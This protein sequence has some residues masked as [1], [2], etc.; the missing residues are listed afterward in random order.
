LA[1]STGGANEPRVPDDD[2]VSTPVRP[3]YTLDQ[4]L[5][6]ITDENCHAETEWG[7]PVGR[8]AW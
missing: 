8:E 1:E 4:L 3:A 7:P 5:D 6:G 2:L